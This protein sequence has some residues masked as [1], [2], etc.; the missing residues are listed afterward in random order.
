MI[1]PI[2]L[3][4]AY[5]REVIFFIKLL[6][7]LIDY[8]KLHN[9]VRPVV[10]YESA[11]SVTPRAPLLSLISLPDFYIGYWFD[12][13]STSLSEALDYYV[14]LGFSLFPFDQ[15]CGCMCSKL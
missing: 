2:A 15:C 5:A 14:F 7:Y 12:T 6:D 13:T 4:L 9:T 10:Y 11:P 8:C 1:E 3:S